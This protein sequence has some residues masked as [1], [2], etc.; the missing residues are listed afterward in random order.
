MLDLAGHVESL[1]AF[2]FPA[3]V[4]QLSY[5]CIVVVLE[6][7]GMVRV[8]PMR[9]VVVRPEVELEIEAGFDGGRRAEQRLLIVVGAHLLAVLGDFPRQHLRQNEAPAH[10]RGEV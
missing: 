4:L 5:S 3:L 10:K 8:S 9:R 1:G 6:C 7:V 2:I